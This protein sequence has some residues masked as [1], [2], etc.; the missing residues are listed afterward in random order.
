MAGRLPGSI[1]SH[2]RL[3]N[4]QAPVF[5]KAGLKTASESIGDRK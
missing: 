2:E 5:M 4:G 1:H 3:E